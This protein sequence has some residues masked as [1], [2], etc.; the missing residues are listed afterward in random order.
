MKH[1]LIGYTYQH[2]V[3]S[4]LLS[5]MD[6]RRTIERL[7]I[8]VDAEHK[9]DDVN[10]VV[11]GENYF[12][13]IK[14]FENVSLNDLVIS[15]DSVKIQG[16]LHRLST[17]IN[18]IFFK[19]ID[20]D[21]DNEILGFS[22]KLHHGVHIVSLSR[23]EIDKV[24]DELYKVDRW[25]RNIIDQFLDDKL[26]KR[27]FKI[28]RQDLPT[29]NFYSTKL[30]EPTVDVARAILSNEKLLL[31]EG[32]PGIGKSH[33]VNHLIN[34]IDSTIVYR[35]WTSN[36][37]THKQERLMFENFLVDISKR[38]FTDYI[39]RTEDDIINKIKELGST[40][41]IDGLDHVENYN[42]SDLERY[43][44]FFDQLKES[45][46]IIVLSRPLKRQLEWKKQL[47][48]NWN[49]NQTKQ[50]LQE[51]YHFDEYGD[52]EKIYSITNGYPILVRYI[53]EH[54]KKYG[55]I[56][57]F[58]QFP[59]VNSY[60]DEIVGKENGKQALALF[61]CTSAYI[62]RSE[63]D[64]FL[65]EE[66]ASIVH[67]FIDERP[68]LFDLRLNRVTLFHDS[69][70]TYLRNT[71]INYS[72][73]SQ[74][75]LSLAY[76]SVMSGEKCFQSRLIH[77][78]FSVEQIKSIVIKYASLE[79][80]QI[81]MSD[82]IDYEATRE[83]YGHIR[84]M[85]ISLDP[86]DLNINQ[87][88]DLALIFCLVI[89]DHTSTLNGFNYTY[90]KT[91]FKNGYNE[92]SI[93]SNRY[94]YGMLYYL[95]TSDGSFLE[96]LKSDDMY[97]IQRFYQELENEL[98]EEKAFFRPYMRPLSQKS[99]QRIIENRDYV[100]YQDN[101]AYI[102]ADLYVNFD[103]RNNFKVFFATIDNFMKGSEKTAE[104]LLKPI[105]IKG[106]YQDY[107][108]RWILEAARKRLLAMG[109]CGNQN[110]FMK[111]SLREYLEKNKS[112]GSF[113]TW[114][115]LLD[116]MRLSLY[117]NRS[118][119]IASISA[120]W[121]KY[122]QRHDYTLLN[123]P[124]ALAV[125]EDK[126]YADWRDSVRL[127]KEIQ[128]ISEKGYRWL[129]GSY[130]EEKGIGFLDQLLSEFDFKDLKISWFLLPTEFIDVLPQEVFY[131]ELGE[132]MRYHSYSKSIELSG[133]INAI[134]SN[135][136]WLLKRDFTWAN[137][138]VRVKSNAPEINLLKKI[139][140]QIETYKPEYYER[141]KR[142]KTSKNHKKPSLIEIAQTPNSNYTAL[143][144]PE[145]FRQF[146]QNDIRESIYKIFYYALTAKPKNFDSFNNA[147]SLPGSMIKI[148]ADADVETDYYSL[149]KSFGSF[150]ELS[151][152]E[153]KE[154]VVSDIRKGN[155]F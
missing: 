20:V 1:A 134:K 54:Y 140:L 78:D 13:Q 115:G 90:L 74:K 44:L 36:Q 63:V 88:Y 127:I 118:I 86:E 56:P 99:I 111:L 131:Y 49:F 72:A 37:D 142:H 138:K 8:E 130:I 135:K 93:T 119:D 10:V 7:E 147:F 125:F 100:N 39:S 67:E 50:V 68:Y 136:L 84:E 150:L 35:F 53:A 98:L 76:N 2:R 144:E 80:F 33:L 79:Y 21:V 155:R 15:G 154:I 24:V 40:V 75:V 60:Y 103:Q 83:F 70:L 137:F 28:S 46:D 9:F 45:S 16:K 97:D 89:R 96:N 26:D 116:F 128:A 11:G 146:T 82:M 41:V 91:L 108:A 152:Y 66:T 141:T 102:L 43:I 143:P 122:Y 145:K 48:G 120:F 87:Y 29:V 132:E 117:Q 52:A 27:E 114:K 94:L 55:Q 129:L 61:L 4:L 133:I 42:R 85:L 126:G 19:G 32:K 104:D 30:T 77:F 12:F 151:Q 81:Q 95:K 14:D 71:K 25:R 5:L 109:E 69:L 92:E 47:L 58:G 38:L 59:D 105:V 65:G 112:K 22:S 106:G 64:L 153:L 121:T 57:D 149:F 139:G 107:Y 6:A 18:I 31:I 51:L 17:G 23:I 124:W 73:I 148:L 3:T 62:M 113:D 34:T 110:D 123:I 101:L